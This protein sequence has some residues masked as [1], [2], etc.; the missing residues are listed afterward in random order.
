MTGEEKRCNNRLGFNKKLLLTFSDTKPLKEITASDMAV[1]AKATYLA[2]FFHKMSIEVG[3]VREQTKKIANGL[4]V[5]SATKEEWEDKLSHLYKKIV[6][7]ENERNKEIKFS[8]S[9]RDE[10]V[11]K[12][13]CKRTLGNSYDIV[14]AINTLDYW[15]SELKMAQDTAELASILEF[16]NVGE[17]NPTFQKYREYRQALEVFKI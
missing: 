15:K 12:F 4:C 14:Q 8:K 2:S 3:S 1:R 13:K 17:K 5:G 10:Y 16:V 7:V 6:R 11:A 9:S